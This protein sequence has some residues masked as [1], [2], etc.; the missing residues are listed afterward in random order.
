MAIRP[1]RRAA[2]SLKS[3]VPKNCIE[4]PLRMNSRFELSVSLSIP[5]SVNDIREYGM[6]PNLTLEEVCPLL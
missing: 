2:N 6:P 5:L 1:S 3:S 4:W